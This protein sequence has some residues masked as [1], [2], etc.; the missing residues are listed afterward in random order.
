[1]SDRKGKV[2]DL[3]Q[4]RMRRRSGGLSDIFHVSHDLVCLCRSGRIAAINSAGLR[5]LGAASSDS[6]NGRRLAR[7]LLPEYRAIL[8]RPL[9]S[10]DEGQPI[11]AR[12]RG[13]D[14]T[15]RDIEVRVYPARR[16]A[17]DMTAVIARRV[18]PM[19]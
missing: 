8:E 17:A 3:A 7:F 1:M 4:E 13:L 16:G 11:P 14:K 5:L 10:K 2:V 18:T 6:L 9:A 12:L 19:A 15:I